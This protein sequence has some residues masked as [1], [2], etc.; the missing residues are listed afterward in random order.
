MK[1]AKIT[2][3]IVQL[4]I[5]MLTGCNKLTEEEKTRFKE[6]IIKNDRQY[7]EYILSKGVDLNDEKTFGYIPLHIAVWK[8]N[9]ELIQLF[10]ERG[11]NINILNG[12]DQNCL[13]QTYDINTVEYLIEH[14]ANV[15]QVDKDGYIPLILCSW[16]YELAKLYIE[17][18]ANYKHRNR[19]GISL[20]LAAVSD[21]NYE[22]VKYLINEKK[23]NVNEVLDNGFNAL[24][25]YM[26]S[27]KH[28]EELKNNNII[29]LLLN[30]G[31]N[32]NH[33]DNKGF[34]ALHIGALLNS[35]KEIMQILLNH[36]ADVH[37]KNNKGKTPLDIAIERGNTD[38][39]NLLKRYSR[40][41]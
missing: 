17:K 35:E 23:I 3:L 34:T 10:L 18:G 25:W 12:L 32:I 2:I 41:R 15:N 13:F 14:G 30:K 33:K 24:M 20:F 9:I 29:I 36:G 11:T 37:I 16:H 27:I 40:K 28:V 31:I 5:I 8:N 38:I 4:I 26:V 7:V 19:N 22:L 1:I 39:I 21:G 6:A